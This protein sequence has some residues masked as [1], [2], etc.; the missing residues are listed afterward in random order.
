MTDP[1]E[2]ATTA[3]QFAYF[4][5]RVRVGAPGDAASFAGVVERLGTG[6]K[7]PFPDADALVRLLS[8]WSRVLPKMWSA[9]SGSNGPEISNAGD[10]PSP[11]QGI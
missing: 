7:R 11:G 2:E 9:P 4:M 8:D 5:V 6:R 10:Q 1:V 3:E